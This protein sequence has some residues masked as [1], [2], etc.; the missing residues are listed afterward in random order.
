MGATLE[1]NIFVD[2]KAGLN[3]FFFFCFFLF[4]GLRLMSMIAVVDVCM[5]LRMELG[6]EAQDEL[7]DWESS[8]RPRGALIKARGGEDCTVVNLRGDEIRPSQERREHIFVSSFH[9]LHLVK[10]DK[11]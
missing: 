4:S 9:S 3:F 10:C 5:G 8:Y 6:R 11:F 7:H 2:S 1:E